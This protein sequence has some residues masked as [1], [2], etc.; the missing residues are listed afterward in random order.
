VV[1]YEGDIVVHEGSTYQ[2]KRDTSRAPPHADWACIAAAGRDARMP[3]VCGT[4]R[5]GEIYNYLDIVALN[6]SAF[7][8]RRDNPNEC[9]G[10]GWQLIASAG[11][12][13]KLG[14]K[15]ERGESGPRG[16]RGLPGQAAPT[17]QGW[18]VD[19]K[20]YRA[21]PL[22]SDGSE[23]P[24]LELRPLFEQYHTECSGD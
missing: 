11:R 17:I 19:T 15:G 23:G 20:R 4:Y 13:G 22:M 7:I 3:K 8:A 2:A 6:G 14:P 24:V 21:T 16:E 1:H 9:P 12:A 18:R 5:E 10:D